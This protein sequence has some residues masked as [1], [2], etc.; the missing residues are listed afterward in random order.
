MPSL[1]LFWSLRRRTF[2]LFRAHTRHPWTIPSIKW[3]F[4][5]TKFRWDTHWLRTPILQ[6]T[7]MQRPLHPGRWVEALTSQDRHCFFSQ[8]PE[9]GIFIVGSPIGHAGVFSLCFTKREDHEQP[10]YGF[11][12]EYLLPFHK[13][14]QT[15]IT[16]VP[17]GRLL[18]IAVAPIQGT[19]QNVHLYIQCLTC[20]WSRHV[21]R[22][23]RHW[24][25]GTR[26]RDIATKA[27]ALVNV[28]HGSH[29]IEL[30]AVED[31]SGR[32][33]V[34]ERYGCLALRILYRD[35]Q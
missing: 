9:L 5:S 17:Q 22:S 4:Q 13:S 8:I 30:W 15:K 26:E 25:I 35:Y 32:V 2:F 1:L 29:R 20:V 27:M 21:W 16:G 7:A 3:E 24:S 11:K 23:K 31:E 33:T 10:R 19:M 12:L 6:V 34:L 18:G 28:L 14:D